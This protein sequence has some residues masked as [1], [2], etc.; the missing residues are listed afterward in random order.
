M[1]YV[2][3]RRA[4]KFATQRLKQAKAHLNANEKE[5]FYDELLKAI[6]GYL[7][8]KL[9]I[10]LSELSRE[11]ALE[12]LKNKGIEEETIQLL[13]QVIDNCEF[14]RYA[15]SAAGITMKE[16]Y[17]KAIDLITKLQRKLK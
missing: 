6:W 4:D 8:D 9:N 3:N 12:L 7:S 16:D 10:P 2:K 1:A 5:K 14:A 15:P 17:D 13:T 11:S